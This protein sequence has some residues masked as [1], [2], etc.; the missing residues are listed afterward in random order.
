MQSRILPA[1]DPKKLARNREAQRAFRLRQAQRIAHH[2]YAVAGLAHD[3]RNRLLFL[4]QQIDYLADTAGDLQQAIAMANLSDTAEVVAGDGGI[5]PNWVCGDCA[6]SVVTLV[7][8]SDSESERRLE[9]YRSSLEMLPSLMGTDL[10]RRYLE[11][12]SKLPKCEGTRDIKD[13][14]TQVVAIREELLDECSAT[15]WKRALDILEDIQESQSDAES[16]ARISRAV[17]DISKAI[18]VE[19]LKTRAPLVPGFMLKSQLTQALSRIPHLAPMPNLIDNFCDRCWD[20]FY[21]S[22]SDG[23]ALFVMLSV[24]QEVHGLC[25]QKDERIQLSMA[26]DSSRQF[27]KNGKS[28]FSALQK[29]I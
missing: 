7:D 17:S 5:Y 29:L 9:K 20:Y 6:S 8:V 1:R 18:N 27:S 26:V 21:A 3:V 15:D 28:R 22:D 13:C 24:F 11:M 14:L 16:K 2:Q 19:D 10:A 4:Q 12:S 25:T 23:S